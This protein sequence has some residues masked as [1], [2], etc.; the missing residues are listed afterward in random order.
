MK[1]HDYENIMGQ[2]SL[3]WYNVEGVVSVTN[4]KSFSLIINGHDTSIRSLY[5]HCIG[6]VEDKMLKVECTKMGTASSGIIPTLTKIGH[7]FNNYSVIK[8][9]SD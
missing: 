4:E 3:Y 7:Y 2:R 1:F 8:Q 6:T 5:W 9:G